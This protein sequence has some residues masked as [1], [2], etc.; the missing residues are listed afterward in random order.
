MIIKEV[1]KNNY[2]DIINLNIYENQKGFI[3]SSIQCIEEASECEYY[4]PAGLYVDNELVDFAMYGSFPKE[5]T[6]GRV[7]LDRYFIDKKYQGKGYGS[8]F[9]KQ[10]TKHLVKKYNC[11]EI[12]LTV[13][14][15]NTFA[16]NMYERFGFKING[17]KDFNGKEVMVLKVN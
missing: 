8:I 4:E 2:Q 1:D 17:E 16:I 7:W 9:L 12:Y 5:G 6:N 3:E 10:L 13:Y 14:N 15:D 11:N